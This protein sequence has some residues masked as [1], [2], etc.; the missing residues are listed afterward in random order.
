MDLTLVPLDPPAAQANAATGAPM[1]CT[2]P[3]GQ[4]APDTSLDMGTA[5]DCFDVKAN[6]DASG[7]T[8]E[9]AVNREMLMEVMS[10]HGFKNYEKEWWHYTLENEPFPN[11][12]FDFPVEPRESSR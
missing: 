2:A 7:L 6:T 1:S 5:F 3:R 9:Q 11:T 4:R 8:D 10:R 12:T